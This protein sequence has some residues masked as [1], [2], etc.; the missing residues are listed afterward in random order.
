M[1]PVSGTPVPFASAGAKAERDMRPRFRAPRESASRSHAGRT[2]V[3]LTVHAT[4][5]THRYGRLMDGG[6]WDGRQRESGRV[7]TSRPVAGSVRPGRGLA[8]PGAP[9]PTRH[10]G[11][12]RPA[13]WRGYRSHRGA[14]LDVGQ[15]EGQ[16]PGGQLGHARHT[17]RLLLPCR[18]RQDGVLRRAAGRRPSP[19]LWSCPLK[20]ARQGTTIAQCIPALL[21]SF[22]Y[23]GGDG[24][25][26]SLRAACARG[27]RGRGPAAPLAGEEAI[28]PPP[29]DGGHAA[30]G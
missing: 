24:R 11:R 20:A 17:A 10:G 1:R 30:H 9:R 16:R 15:Q 28:V 27:T 29:Q 2:L 18:A 3:A 22:T 23:L 8:A 21:P 6:R 14:A 13:W 5:G 4:L 12:G 25:L 26:S 7:S 19:R